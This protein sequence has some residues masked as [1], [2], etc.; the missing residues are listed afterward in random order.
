MPSDIHCT[1]CDHPTACHD[2]VRCGVQVVGGVVCGCGRP[3]P[4]SDEAI[5]CLLRYEGVES[6]T[7][8]S[9]AARRRN[10]AKTYPGLDTLGRL[11]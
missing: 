1:T 4:I 11:L 8:G 5:H 7:P 3:K 6:P 10:L 9:V 2:G